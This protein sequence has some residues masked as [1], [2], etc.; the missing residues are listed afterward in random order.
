MP[1]Q[2]GTAIPQQRFTAIER[3]RLFPHGIAPITLFSGPAGMGKTV[4]ASQWVRS[5]D[6]A[7]MRVCWVRVSEAGSGPGDLWRAVREAL[8]GEEVC[9]E[10]GSALGSAA[11]IVVAQERTAA[12][13]AVTRLTGPT[14][15]VIDDYQRLTRSALDLELAELP[16]LSAQLHLTV[17]SRRFAALDGPLVA[18][19]SIVQVLRGDHFAF[20][21]DDSRDLG[22]RLGIASAAVADRIHVG[23]GGW[24]YAVRL[25]LKAISDGA[26]VDDLDAISERFVTDYTER[27]LSALGQRALYVTAVCDRA[28]IELLSETIGLAYAETAS[29]VDRICELGLGTLHWYPGGARLRCHPG[30]ATALRRRARR[31][32]GATETRQLQHQH[33]IELSHDEPEQGIR[34]LLALREY[35]DASRALSTVFPERIGATGQVFEPLHGVPLEDLAEHPFLLGAFL[36]SEIWSANCTVDEAAEMRAAL[37]LAVAQYADPA[38]PERY[39]PMRAILVAVERLDD[40][41][42]ALE[43]ARELERELVAGYAANASGVSFTPLHLATPFIFSTIAETGQTSGD[44]RLAARCFQRAAEWAEL[45]DAEAKQYRAYTGIAVV[46]AIN[47]E[48]TRARSVLAAADELTELLPEGH[49]ARGSLNVTVAQLLIAAEV[50]DR[51]AL[52]EILATVTH[53]HATLIEWPYLALGEA[54]VARGRDGNLAAIAGLDARI[55]SAERFYP[56][57][58]DPQHVLEAYAAQVLATHGNYRESESRLAALPERLPDGVLGRARLAL[59]HGDTETALTLSSALLSG[60]VSTWLRIAARLVRASAHWALGDSRAALTDFEAAAEAMAK[61]GSYSGLELVPF[62]SLRELAIHSQ[63]PQAAALLTVVEALPLSNRCTPYP[64][65]TD[66]EL[67][68]LEAVAESSASLPAIAETLFVT[69]HTVKFHLRSVYRKLRVQGRE[70][71][72]TRA[73]EIGLVDPAPVS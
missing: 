40:D 62:D 34:A 19:R 50:G 67:R 16:E 64:A 25:L 8:T 24:P 7:H 69:P 32:L 72:A 29:I 37:R 68:I 36:L 13:R 28:S 48:I 51:V 17:L 52:P 44:L 30:F 43:L 31:E 21:A 33:A 57:R 9:E 11:R 23:A 47:G 22:R 1:P 6:L 3:E 20:T 53:P 15:L 18:A 54:E 56:H 14:M 73:R 60:R 10:R 66:A 61:H 70:A 46:A 59:L 71:A 58:N 39:F 12:H 26:T 5:A 42:C 63:H 41:V 2:P 27:S 4:L 38:E 45:L 65:L 55:R 49:S 35:T